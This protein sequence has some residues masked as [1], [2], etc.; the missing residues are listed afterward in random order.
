MPVRKRL[1]RRIVEDLLEQAGV[2]AA[3]VPV[4]RIAK[5][6]GAQV[7][8][9]SADD[10][11]SGFLY[12]AA[13]KGKRP[14]IGINDEHNPRR[15]RFS[16]AHELGHLILH[17]GDPLHVDRGNA[18]QIKLRSEASSTGTDPDEKEANAFAAELLM[19]QKF[20]ERDLEDLDALDDDALQV[21]AEK[22]E[23]S[24]QA[25]AFRLANLGYI[26]LE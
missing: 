4:E 1:I 24:Q 23:V 17:T 16:I 22:Y 15:Q 9:E 26:E 19:P 3:P 6:A 11:L 13:G 21:L 5:Q 14:I 7:A 18:L 12:R 25:M 8:Y 10:N 2:T 20:V